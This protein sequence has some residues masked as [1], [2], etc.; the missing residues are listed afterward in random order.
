MNEGISIKLITFAYY[1]VNATLVTSRRSP[2]KGQGQR[3]MFT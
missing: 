2:I 3:A 1:Q